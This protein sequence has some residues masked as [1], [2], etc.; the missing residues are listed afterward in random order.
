MEAGKVSAKRP[1]AL[2]SNEFE[3]I[4]RFCRHLKLS[5]RTILGPGDDCAI[6]EPSRWPS[7][8]TID[9]TVEGLHFKVDWGTPEQIGARSVLV[10]LSDIAA[11]GATPT[12]CVVNL[13]VRAGLSDKFLERLYDGLKG[14]VSDSSMD[15]VGGN[16]TGADQ[17]AITI[18]VIGE[19][20]GQALRRGNA[21]ANDEIFVTGTLGDAAL[22]WRIL[23]GKLALAKGKNRN[24]LIARYLRP[25]PRIRPGQL[26]AQIKPA[27]AAIDVSDGLAQDLGHVLEKSNVG[28]EIEID[29]IP[30]S[31][32]YCSVS[33]PNRDLA[34]TGGED[35]E[36]LFTIRP[37]CSQAALSKR[38]GLSVRR[39]GRITRRR[40]LRILHDGKPARIAAD[41]LRGWDQLGDL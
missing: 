13:A 1:P 39:I 6:V 5:R 29:A 16:I 23:D 21:R 40:G 15:L 25:S 17:L 7:V 30:V 31:R 22:G 27:A 9:S 10:N 41:S 38:L 11:M 12:H 37:G 32:A 19:L 24:W 36:L 2:A 20:R 26:L 35:Y 33:G 34:L 8:T 3:L 18:T 14:A 4:A 28:A